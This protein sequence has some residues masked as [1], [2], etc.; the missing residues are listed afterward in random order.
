MNE[1]L[2]ALISSIA[3]DLYTDELHRYMVS[4]DASIFK[5]NPACVIYPR[6]TEDVCRVAAFAMPNK[7]AIHCR[8][9]GSGLCG[10]AVG[11][12]IVLDFTKYMNRLIRI[13]PEEKNFE[14][15]PGFRLGELTAAL[16]GRGLFFPPDPSSGEYASFGGMYGTNASGAHSVK[17]GNVSD[18]IIDAQIVLAS[19]LITT[20]SDIA[21]T[22]FNELPKNL[23]HLFQLYEKHSVYYLTFF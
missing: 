21:A 9:A 1:P 8:G 14:C 22:A 4:T 15:Q 17:Y 20:L 13:D 3:G 23:K 5:V 10:S 19:G 18:Y 2:R 12:G 7:M 16:K 11:S 6:N